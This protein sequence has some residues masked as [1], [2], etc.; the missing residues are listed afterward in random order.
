MDLL[1]DICHALLNLKV[2]QQV[3]WALGKKTVF[4]LIVIDL[5]FFTLLH[6]RNIIG[7]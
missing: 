6:K 1:V 3:T 2:G 4:M 7:S 5:V